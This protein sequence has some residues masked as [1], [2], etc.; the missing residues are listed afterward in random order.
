VLIDQRDQRD[1]RAERVGEQAGQTIENGLWIGVE[2]LKRVKKLQTLNF[3]GGMRRNH[4]SS[5]SCDNIAV[6]GSEKE[7]FG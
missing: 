3:V 2:D 4:K 5:R 6:C 7:G 1:W